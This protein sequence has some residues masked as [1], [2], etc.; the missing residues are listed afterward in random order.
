MILTLLYSRKLNRAQEFF[1]STKRITAPA[2]EM[3]VL[4]K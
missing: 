1:E 4:Y 2:A 3:E